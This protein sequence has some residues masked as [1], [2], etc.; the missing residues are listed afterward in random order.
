MNKLK[1]AGFLLIILPLEGFYVTS[2]VDSSILKE[3]CLSEGNRYEWSNFFGGSDLDCGSAIQQTSD[4]GYIVV[5]DTFSYVP[6]PMNITGNGWLIKLDCFGNE[7]WNKTF[8]WNSSFRGHWYASFRDVQ[9]TS[10]GGYIIVGT[11]TVFHEG[12]PDRDIWVIKTDSDGNKIWD[13]FFYEGSD[14]FGVSIRQTSDG[15]FIV[16]GFSNSR[17]LLVKLDEYGNKVWNRSFKRGKSNLFLSVRETGDDG[18]IVAGWAG[19]K[20]PRGFPGDYDFWLVKVD[21]NGFEEWNKTYGGYVCRRAFGVE[22]TRDHGYIVAGEFNYQ[23]NY[24][25]WEQIIPGFEARV[26]KVDEHGNLEWE[27][28]LG[29]LTTYETC[30]GLCKT[31]DGKSFITIGYMDNPRDSFNHYDVWVTMLDEYGRILWERK[32]GGSEENWGYGVAPTGDG[33]CI[34]A[35]RIKQRG[36]HSDLFIVKIPDFYLNKPSSGGLY[37][38]DKE[39]PL[40][41]SIT[42]IIIGGVTLNVSSSYDLSKVEFYIDDELRY[43]DEQPPFQWYWNRKSYGKHVLKAIG[44]V[45]TGETVSHAVEVF[46]ILNL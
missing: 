42:P 14:D 41:L 15:G 5:G 37:I 1:L 3:T 17:A 7:E 9:Q 22:E 28:K 12:Y 44:F 31:C 38:L 18:F 40:P 39:Y 45:S 32:I 34:V 20:G 24:Y 35:G 36:R 2:C 27:R 30:R 25:N 4:G 13:R 29:K 10:D 6:D 8:E 23:I 11:L 19:E 16:A 46:S 33:G 21:E 26:I 43:V